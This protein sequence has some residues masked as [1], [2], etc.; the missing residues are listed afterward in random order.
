MFQNTWYQMGRAIVSFYAHTLMHTDIHLQSP[1]PQGAKIIAA[2]HPCT[3]DPAFVTLITREHVTIL[4]K[5]SLF[6]MPLFGRSLR[7]SG[8][9]PVICGDGQTALDAGIRLLK[10]GHTVM[11]FPE[12]EISPDDGY[13]PA[14]TGVA[15]LALASGAPVIPVGISLNQKKV[16]R[17]PT[18]IDGAQDTGTWYLQGSYAMTVGQPM[19][20]NGDPN[21]RDSAR[22]V[23][24]QVM[25]RIT[26]LSR[27]GHLRMAL[28]RAA[29]PASQI[30]LTR[31][32]A[33][34]Q[35]AWRETWETFRQTARVVGRSPAFRTVESLFIVALMYIK[36]F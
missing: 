21:N 33:T 4:I 13:Q 6:K 27:S 12:G 23:T 22:L 32:K 11:I 19:H 30:S 3:N 9:V 29:S 17:V 28:N 10:A 15:R 24:S 18:M 36:H 14:H 34:V 8:H 26:T 16:R 31:P 2:N 5:G 25:A 7:M 35:Y 1:L 20:F